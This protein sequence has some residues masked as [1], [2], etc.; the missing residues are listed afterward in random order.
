MEGDGSN[1]LDQPALRLL[2]ACDPAVG[3]THL[4]PG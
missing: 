4:T 2:M 3:Q 1:I